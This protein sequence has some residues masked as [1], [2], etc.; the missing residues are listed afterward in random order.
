M[1]IL[2]ECPP[3]NCGYEYAARSNDLTVK[4]ARQAKIHMTETEPIHGHRQYG[5]GI[6]QG[7]VFEELRQQSAEALVELDFDGYAIGG[8]AV[9]EPV[10]VMYHMTDHVTRFLPEQKPRYLM[11][12]GTPLNLLEGIARGVDMFDCVMPTRNG[13]NA[14]IFTR[15]GP[16]SIKK[17]KFLHDTGP[18]DAACTCYACR[19]FTRSYVCHLFRTREILGLQLASLHNVSF[20]LQLI[21]EAREAILQGCFE[22]WMHKVVHQYQEAGTE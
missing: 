14:M 8:L 20:Y 5:F 21:R 22:N 2:D 4:W 15:Q 16:I 3:A 7:N 6:V 1:M 18:L 19:E 10:D 11:G 13:R 17:E 9:G 12:V